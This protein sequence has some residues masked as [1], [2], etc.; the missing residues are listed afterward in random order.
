MKRRSA[1]ILA[2]LRTRTVRM[3]LMV[4]GTAGLVAL[5]TGFGEPHVI[6]NHT[7]PLR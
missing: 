4:P 3:L 2:R 6:G 7:E 5:L 1:A